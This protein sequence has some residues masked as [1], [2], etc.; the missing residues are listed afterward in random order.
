MLS[1]RLKELKASPTLAL[2]AKAKQLQSEGHDIVSLTVGE[3]DW[4]TYDKAKKAAKIAIDENKTTY[5]PASGIPQ[6]RQ[7][8]ADLISPQLGVPIKPNQVTVGAGAKFIIYAALVALLDEGDEVIIPSPYWVSYPEMVELAG[9]KPKI[10]KCDQ[11]TNFKMTAEQF[12]KAIG[13]KTKVLLLNSPS[14]PTGAEYTRKELESIVE[15]LN[16]N[17]QIAIIS[18]DIYN[19][20]SFSKESLS[21][22]VININPQLFSRCVSVNG[23][24]KAYSMTG[25]RIGWAVGPEEIIKAMGNFQSQTTGASCSISQWASVT[26][27]NDCKQEVKDALVA[28]K[29]RKDFFIE[30]ISSVKGLKIFNPDGAFYLWVNVEAWLNK[31]YLNT[32]LTDSKVIAERLLEDEK[33]AVVPGLEFGLDGYL[34]LSFA[35]SRENLLKAVERFNH[36]QNSL[37]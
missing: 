21:T 25:W 6:L 9:G 28:L 30:Q 1:K 37:K 8:I 22:H 23:I 4:P 19:Q 24:S 17:P 16:A 32:K 18:D 15:V 20:L 5:T 33:L 14:N 10:V 29:Q 26:A 7:A 3:P 35:A 11:Q 12:K 13:P 27:I 2:A 31:T 34:R 36:F